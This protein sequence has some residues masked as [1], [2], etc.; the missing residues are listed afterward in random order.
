[1][2]SK[3]TH[4]IVEEHFGH[5]TATN[6]KK[7]VDRHIG[8]TTTTTPAPKPKFA[9]AMTTEEFRAQVNNYMDSYIT[10]LTNIANSVTATELE[11]VPIEKI[12]FENIEFLGDLIKDIYPLTIYEAMTQ[13]FRSTTLALIQAVHLVR[14]G[15][16]TKDWVNNRFNTLL[17]DG[18]ANALSSANNDWKYQTV[19]DL[20]I[21]MTNSLVAMAKARVAKNTTLEQQLATKARDAAT[22]FAKAFG[23]GVISQHPELFVNTPKMPA[24][25]SRSDIM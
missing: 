9:T 3:I 4:T 11:M 14:V 7:S 18:L 19:K 23:D 22:N 13:I 8:H 2:Y 12:A 5:P 6:I 21:S 24:A 25:T 20:Y 10:K 16:D 15:V 1:M 17:G